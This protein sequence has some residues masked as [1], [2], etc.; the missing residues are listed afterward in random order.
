MKKNIEVK[1]QE[2]DH[3]Y[4]R[5]ENY[6]YYPNEE[7]VK[8]LNRFVKKKMSINQEFINILGEE[9]LKALDFG[10]GIGRNTIL[11][12]EF[13]IESYGI[14][15]SQVAINEAKELSKFYGFDMDNFFTVYDGQH[16]DFQ[17]GFFDFV[18]CESVLDSMSMSLAKELIKQI[19]KVTK[20]LCYLT[21]ISSDSINM[22][23]K[24]EEK[25]DLEIV[26]KE[27]HEKDTIQ[28][29]FDVPKIHE[30][31]QGTAFKIKWGELISNKNLLNEKRFHGRYYIVLEK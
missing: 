24:Y 13:G 27:N 26:V 16:L 5:K 10:C 20:S 9:K 2:W 11:M 31:I 28:S 29:F 6:A 8:F 14:D 7:V 3:S 4:A 25:N 12:K 17:E 21:L 1:K 23:S 22:F 30:L 15:I 19:D 18:I